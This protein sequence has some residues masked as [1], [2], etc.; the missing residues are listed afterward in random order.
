MLAPGAEALRQMVADARS[1]AGGVHGGALC[2]NITTLC[3]ES[4]ELAAQ[5][6]QLARRGMVRCRGGA[7]V[8]GG[9][10]VDF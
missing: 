3:D 9:G 6:S 2:S 7:S 4:T 5:L 1:V 8:L 10:G